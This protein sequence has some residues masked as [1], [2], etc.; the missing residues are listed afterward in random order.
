MSEVDSDDWVFD[1]EFGG[2]RS[3]AMTWVVS[4]MGVAAPGHRQ[5]PSFLI[6]FF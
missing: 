6:S 5:T 4:R 1:L 2:R 3:E